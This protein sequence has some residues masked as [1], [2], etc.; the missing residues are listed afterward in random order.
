MELV[1]KRDPERFGE[2]LGGIIDQG[3]RMLDTARVSAIASIELRDA[4]RTD[5]R[6]SRED[7][8]DMARRVVP[9][10]ATTR[11]KELPPMPDAATLALVAQR[12]RPLVERLELPPANPHSSSRLISLAR[13]AR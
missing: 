4:L 13:D 10:L 2:E 8:F 5:F 3:E 11:V 9:E 7:L 1:A 6:T 12:L